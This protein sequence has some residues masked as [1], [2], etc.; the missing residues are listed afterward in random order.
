MHTIKG[1]S[2]MMGFDSLTTVAHKVE[3]LFYFVREH[4]IKHEHNEKLIE[5]TFEFTDFV[6]GEVIKIEEGRELENNTKPFEN[7]IA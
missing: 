2:A 4:G 6:K 7:E 3:D 5:L 1:S